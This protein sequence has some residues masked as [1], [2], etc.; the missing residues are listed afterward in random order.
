MVQIR[1]LSFVGMNVDLLRGCG[2]FLF[3]HSYLSIPAA[4][5]QNGKCSCCNPCPAMWFS[6]VTPRTSCCFIRPSAVTEV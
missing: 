5:T 1:Y 4:I 6:G 2:L 3:H